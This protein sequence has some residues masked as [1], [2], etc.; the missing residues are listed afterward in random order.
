[1]H[2]QSNMT[3]PHRTN[4]ALPRSRDS[5]SMNQGSLNWVN[6]HFFFPTFFKGI[7]SETGA[8]ERYKVYNQRNERVYNIASSGQWQL[9]SICWADTKGT[10]AP[11]PFSISFL[12]AANPTSSKL[13]LKRSQIA[14][15]NYFPIAFTALLCLVQDS[16]PRLWVRSA[17]PC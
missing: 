1:M 12:L 11:I 6:V 8:G 13:P 3:V 7:Y 17:R 10:E 9:R 16:S 14:F 2:M 5:V 4:I 15:P